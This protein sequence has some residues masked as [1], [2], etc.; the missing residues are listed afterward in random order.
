MPSSLLYLQGENLFDALAA[1][2]NQDGQYDYRKD[3]GNDPNNGY[4]VH[5]NSPFSMSE[6]LVKTFHYGDSRRTQSY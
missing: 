5:V 6:V 2:L 3:S 4:I 1:A